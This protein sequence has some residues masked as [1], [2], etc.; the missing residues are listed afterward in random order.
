M[1]LTIAA[2]E[3]RSLFLSPLA[4]TLLAVAQGLLAWIF[5]LLVQDFQVFLLLVTLQNLDAM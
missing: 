5:L 4:W 1:I 2:R 3:W